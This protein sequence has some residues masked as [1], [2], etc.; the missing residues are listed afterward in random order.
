MLPDESVMTVLST[1]RPTMAQTDGTK[2]RTSTVSLMTAE[3]TDSDSS[4][5][6]VG[7][8]HDHIDGLLLSLLS[9]LSDEQRDCTEAFI[10]SRANVFS[11][12]EY[13]IGRTNIIPTALT[14]VITVLI[15]SSC[16][17]I[18]WLSFRSLTSMCNICSSKMS[19]S[20]LL[21][22]GFQCGDGPQARRY[23]ATVHRLLQ[24][25]WS[26]DQGQISASEN[27]HLP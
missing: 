14:R 9:D 15:S 23:N 10:R 17:V 8:A 5:L 2:V 12:S 18:Q 22:H 26:Y 7:D 27:R 4:T 11:R 21:H 13:D 20:L 1:L 3:P 24:N 19:L 6:P 25:E 16:D